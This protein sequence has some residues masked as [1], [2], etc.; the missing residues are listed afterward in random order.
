MLPRHGS[1]MQVEVRAFWNQK[2]RMLKLLVPL[3]YKCSRYLGQT[4]FGVQDLPINGNEAVAQ[5]WVCAVNASEDK[6]FSCINDGIYG[7]DLS[8][9]DLRLSLLRSPAYSGHPIGDNEFVP[10]DRFTPRIDQGQRIFNFW[11]NAGGI[12]KRLEAISVEAQVKNEKPFALSFFP[13]GG[14][15]CPQPMVL[16]NNSA[17]ELS[18]VKQAESNSDWIIRLFNTTARKHSVRI[19]L[20]AIGMKFT[21]RFVPHEIKTFRVNGKGL[22]QNVNLMELESK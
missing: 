20:P 5:K 17:I 1:E 7:S 8:G 10:A 16:L 3:T 18:A 14:G 15:K 4:A 2:N 11:F 21:E 9:R 6:T 13:K 19:K 22:I 12:K